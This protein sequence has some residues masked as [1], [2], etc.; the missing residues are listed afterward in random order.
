MS[1]WSESVVLA[2]KHLLKAE[3]SLNLRRYAEGQAHLERVIDEL[4]A[5]YAEAAKLREKAA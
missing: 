1:D 3:N 4:E 2:K 5:A